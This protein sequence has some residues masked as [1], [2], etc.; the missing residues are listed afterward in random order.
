MDDAR[1]RRRARRYRRPRDGAR[2]HRPERAHDG[3]PRHDVDGEHR[4]GAGRGASVGGAARDR[5]A[6]GDHTRAE[7][8]GRAHRDGGVGER[9]GTDRART[10]LALERYCGRACECGGACARAALHRLARADGPRHGVERGRGRQRPRD[11][12][13]DAPSDGDGRAGRRDARPRR[14]RSA[15]GRRARRHR[16]DTHRQ[17]ARLDLHRY[18][19]RPRERGRRCHRRVLRRLRHPHRFGDRRDRDACGHGIGRGASA[20]RRKRHHHARWRRST[21]E[22]HAAARCGPP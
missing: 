7:R 10:A 13:A 20:H 22:Q 16:G 12:S 14:D 1:F 2:V 9:S 6:I 5:I 19:R 11:G 18:H 4:H 15:R 8:F 17:P 21:P 3:D